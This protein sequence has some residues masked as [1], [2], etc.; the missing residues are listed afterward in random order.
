[1]TKILSLTALFITVY[2]AFASTSTYTTVGT[3]SCINANGEQYPRVI[4]LGFATVADCAEWC[5][6]V[7]ETSIGFSKLMSY[8]QCVYSYNASIY[9]NHTEAYWESMYYAHNN[10][11]RA[12]G[13]IVNVDPSTAFTCYKF[14]TLKAVA[15]P[16]DIAVYKGEGTCDDADING[17]DKAAYTGIH[18]VEPCQ[19]LCY[20]K[21]TCLGFEI[22]EANDVCYCLFD[23]NDQLFPT[24]A[25]GTLSVTTNVGTGYIDFYTD[26]AGTFCYAFSGTLTTRSPSASPSEAPSMAPSN[27]PSSNPS[28]SPTNNPSGSPT[29][30]PTR[31]PLQP[32]QTAAPSGSPTK[33]PTEA[34]SKAPTGSPSVTTTA[35]PSQ[36]PVGTPTAPTTTGPSASPTPPTTAGPSASPNVAPTPDLGFSPGTEGGTEAG[37]FDSVGNIAGV[38]VGSGVGGLGMLWLLLLLLRRRKQNKEKV[39][40][41]Y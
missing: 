1:M 36:S 27:P 26:K 3:G 4:Y 31:S 2:G 8:C 18:D 41:N 29:M 22:D 21:P 16:D 38:A 14:D 32:G 17:Y 40:P 11:G 33:N 6:N 9:P 24:D 25:D 35:A 23:E 28:S 19:T 7:K 15:I 20:A 13:E 34:P 5:Y 37:F 10:Y 30:K 39:E 12:T